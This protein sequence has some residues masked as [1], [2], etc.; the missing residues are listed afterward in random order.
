MGLIWLP[1]CRDQINL[2]LFNFCT[3]FIPFE[4]ISIDVIT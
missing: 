2:N 1:F 4:I 3:S